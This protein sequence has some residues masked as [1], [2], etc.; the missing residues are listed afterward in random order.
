MLRLGTI[1]AVLGVAAAVGSVAGKARAVVFNAPIDVNATFDDGTSLTG[2]FEI[3]PS[4]S[5][6]GSPWVFVTQAGHSE[7]GTMISAYTFTSASGSASSVAGAPDTYEIDFFNASDSEELDFTFAHALDIGGSDP[8]LAGIGSYY[9]GSPN[10]GQCA[11]SSCSASDE[12]LIV[13]GIAFV[14]EPRSIAMLSTGLMALAIGAQ[15]SKSRSS[16]D[17]R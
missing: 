10:S 6:N 1:F 5:A 11:G 8:I 4:G 17:T 13:S 7:G 16:H 14:P 2:Q 3:S 15:R 12:R 9:P